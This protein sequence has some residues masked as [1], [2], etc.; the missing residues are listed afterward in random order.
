VWHSQCSP[1]GKLVASSGD[2]TVRLWGSAT[3]VE[4]G[5]LFDPYFHC[6]WVYHVAFSPDGKLVAS[7][8]DGTVRLWDYATGTTCNILMKGHSPAVTAVA[9]SPDGKLVQHLNITRL[10]SSGTLPPA[11]CA[12]YMHVQVL[13]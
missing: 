5:T 6:N 3:G 11:W 12:T 2:G 13:F 8:H 4:R 10:S 1:D 9:L 7:D